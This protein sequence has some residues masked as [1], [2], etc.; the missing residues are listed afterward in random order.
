VHAS[1]E[2]QAQAQPRISQMKRAVYP[3]LVNLGVAW[4]SNWW[5]RRHCCRWFDGGAKHEQ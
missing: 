1:V 2:Q 4:C 3:L 5:C